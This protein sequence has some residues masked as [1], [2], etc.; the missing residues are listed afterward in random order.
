VRHGGLYGEV[1]VLVSCR[2]GGCACRKQGCQTKCS[3]EGAEARYYTKS[4]E[5]KRSARVSRFH[6]HANSTR[7][8]RR[9]RFGWWWAVDKSGRWSLMSR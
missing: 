9:W 1:R 5:E 8:L 3:R 6:S 2:V 7:L 4:Y